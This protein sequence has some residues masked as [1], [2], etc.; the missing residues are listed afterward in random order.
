LPACCLLLGIDTFGYLGRGLNSAI[1]GIYGPISS[2]SQTKPMRYKSPTGQWPQK[3]TQTEQ[4]G[5]RMRTEWTGAE[6]QLANW[7]KDTN[8]AGAIYSSSSSS[9]LLPP[10]TPTQLH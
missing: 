1:S 8:M 9:C 4:S 3:K 10:S 5:E 6:V 7:A 2:K